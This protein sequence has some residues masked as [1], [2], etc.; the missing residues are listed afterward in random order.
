MLKRRSGLR[1]LRTTDTEANLRARAR[2]LRELASTG[3]TQSATGD[4]LKQL[5]SQYERRAN[6]LAASPRE[7]DHGQ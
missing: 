6:I 3:A 7:S 2:N 1:E 4:R 5:A